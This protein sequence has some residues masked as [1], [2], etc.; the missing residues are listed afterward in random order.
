MPLHERGKGGLVAGAGVGGQQFV[1][2]QFGHSR[3]NVRRTRNR[4]EFL[5]VFFTVDARSGNTDH[6]LNVCG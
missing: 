1:V 5:K 6:L 3:N 2:S 4:T